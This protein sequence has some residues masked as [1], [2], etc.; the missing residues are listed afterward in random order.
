MI[1]IKTKISIFIYKYINIDITIKLVLVSLCIVLSAHSHL[2]SET[3]KESFD[4]NK[5]KGSE[6]K[7]HKR[8]L[9]VQFSSDYIARGWALGTEDISRRNNLPYKS[10]QPMWAFQPTLEFETPIKKLHIEAFFNIWMKGLPDRDNE[11]RI[12][13]SQSG[14][15]ELY[16]KVFSDLSSGNSDSFCSN[17]VFTGQSCY[18]PID[19]HKYVN[20][21]GMYRNNAGEFTLFYELSEGKYGKINVGGFR[22]AI[23]PTSGSGGLSKTQGFISWE[24]P[25]LKEI[26][27]KLSLYKTINFRNQGTPAT[28]LNRSMFYIPLEFYYEFF[29]DSL[30]QVTPG[31]NI[32]YMY[33]ANPINKTSGFSDISSYIKFTMSHFY[34][35]TYYVKRPDV[36]LYDNNNYFDGAKRIIHDG[37]VQDPSKL[38]GYDNTYIYNQINSNVSDPIVREL[39]K[40]RYNQQKIITNLFYIQFGYATHF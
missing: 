37:Y 8:E 21:N 11:Q 38:Y 22:Y 20:Q 14:G 9:K 10:F 29:K 2:Y 13:Q 33:Q 27:L 32:G 7:S 5:Q 12:L 23:F 39:V 18:N 40:E 31:T 30:I 24:L 34:F 26:H 3:N 28:G 16:T 36:S 19:V 15:G 25:F 1:S 35:T 6:V 17:N 4:I